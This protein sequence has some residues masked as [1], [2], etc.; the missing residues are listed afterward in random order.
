MFRIYLTNLGKYNEGELVGKW[1]DL[2]I[3]DDDLEK[4]YE[5]IKIDFNE[6][7][8]VFI[9]DFE[10]DY[11]YHVDEY[12]SIEE[13]NE[14]ADEF[15]HLTA[16]ET[17]I[18]KVLI[19]QGGYTAEDALDKKDNVI[20]YSDCYTMEDVARQYA[21]SVGLLDEVPDYLQSYFDYEAYGRDME[22]SGQFYYGG[23]GNY[24]EVIY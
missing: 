22:I 9:T 13:L 1:I 3:D 5:E 10:N 18:V 15:E 16:Y 14:I 24:Y 8:E 2:P 19:D 7:E 17:D 21:E 20:V 4:V 6:Y 12:D 11:G 23:D